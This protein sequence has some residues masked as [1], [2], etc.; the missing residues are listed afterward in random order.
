M[1]ILRL[2]LRLNSGSLR[3][4]VSDFTHCFLPI[5]WLYL[6]RNV[7][8]IAMVAYISNTDLHIFETLV[9]FICL[10][11]LHYWQA[12]MTDHLGSTQE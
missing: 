10:L 4:K 9:S 11:A 3:A 7:H 2:C 5:V 12:D 8:G 1:R 6:Q